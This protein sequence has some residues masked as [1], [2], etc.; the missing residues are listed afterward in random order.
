VTVL[1]V[2]AITDSPEAPTLPGLHGASVQR[3]GERVPFAMASE[4]RDLPSHPDEADLWA[5]ERVV[6]DLM[7]RSTVLPM[8][9]GSTITDDA[10]LL[11]MLEGRRHEFETLIEDVR[12]AVELSVRAQLTIAESVPVESAVGPRDSGGN[13]SAYLRQLQAEQR[14]AEDALSMIHEPLVGLARRSARRSSGMRR[15]VLKAAYLVDL[16]RVEEF[17]MRVDGL[18]GEMR[19]ARIACTGPWPPYTFSSGAPK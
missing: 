10:S 11:A 18:A 12:G 3:I 17:R 2:Y 14:A 9:F 4:H 16:E 7:N 1:Y 6:E 19:G 8:Q 5:H 15:D 13:G